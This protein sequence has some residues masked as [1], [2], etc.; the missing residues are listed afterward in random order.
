MPATYKDVQNYLNHLSETKSNMVKPVNLEIDD[1][2][3]HI[4]DGNGIRVLT[5]DK[6][7]Y[8]IFNEL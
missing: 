3:F 4:N 1:N 7:L 6:T 5:L 2:L 8:N